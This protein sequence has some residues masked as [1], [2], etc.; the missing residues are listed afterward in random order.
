[1]VLNNINLMTMMVTKVMNMTMG[2]MNM[3]I[4]DSRNFT[5]TGTK[6]S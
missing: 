4:V 1:M 3:M 6:I 2:M 5:S